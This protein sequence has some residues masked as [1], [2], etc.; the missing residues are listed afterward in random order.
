MAG[1]ASLDLLMSGPFQAV[2]W[3]LIP[4]NC[5]IIVLKFNR[6]NLTRGSSISDRYFRLC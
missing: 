2:I 4:N 1:S 6:E 3:P 5:T